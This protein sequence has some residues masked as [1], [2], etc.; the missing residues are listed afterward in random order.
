MKTRKVWQTGVKF[1][2]LVIPQHVF[3]DKLSFESFF[4]FKFF[5]KYLCFLSA[6]FKFSYQEFNLVRCQIRLAL[7]TVCW[8]LILRGTATAARTHCAFFR[9][10]LF[11]A[12]EIR[13]IMVYFTYVDKVFLRILCVI[14]EIKLFNTS[15]L[16]GRALI[17]TPGLTLLIS[18]L[19]GTC[20]CLRTRRVKYRRATSNSFT[21]RNGNCH[22]RFLKM[23]GTDPRIDKALELFVSTFTERDPLSSPSAVFRK[24]K[25]REVR[26]IMSAISTNS[27][28][29]ILNHGNPK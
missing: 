1:H 9:Y 12:T 11:L 19:S 27:Y 3:N 23:E 8:R 25:I 17:S 22:I 18:I 24:S 16:R 13:V 6:L 29:T 20:C 10:C 2:R 4:V 21:T 14:P 5:F 26:S 15:F 7:R 28:S